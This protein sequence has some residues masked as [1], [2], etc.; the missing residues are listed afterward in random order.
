MSDTSHV[1]VRYRTLISALIEMQTGLVQ[2]IALRRRLP[3]QVE[4][5][6]SPHYVPTSSGYSAEEWPLSDINEAVNAALARVNEIEDL[7]DEAVVAGYRMGVDPVRM[8]RIL[9]RI[10]D[11]CWDLLIFRVT[12]EEVPRVEEDFWDGVL[13]LQQVMTPLEDL[14]TCLRATDQSVEPPTTNLSATDRRI[15]EKL[16]NG[17]RKGQALATDL[18]LSFDYL[19]RCCARLRKLGLL[20]NDE[21]GYYLLRKP[22]E[23]V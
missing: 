9:N 14:L 5:K 22:P 16:C 6:P 4:T 18:G 15:L 19:R 13:K 3:G 11:R 2:K 12:D 8:G 7:R 17:P 20:A 10:A 21:N 1:L 23:P